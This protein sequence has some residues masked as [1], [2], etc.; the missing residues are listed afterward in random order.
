MWKRGRIV[1]CAI[2]GMDSSIFAGRADTMFRKSTSH[3]MVSPW[4]PRQHSTKCANVLS[5]SVTLPV[6][7]VHPSNLSFNPDALKRAPVN[8]IVRPHYHEPDSHGRTIGAH[9]SRSNAPSAFRISGGVSH[10]LF[11]IAAL[12]CPLKLTSSSV[13]SNNPLKRDRPQAAGPLALR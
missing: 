9:G 5:A 1:Y 11:F 6:F 4:K 10:S 3:A 13:W 2:A 7:I 12:W 8:S